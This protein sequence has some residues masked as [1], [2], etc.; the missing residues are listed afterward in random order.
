MSH[1]QNLCST[2]GQPELE[3]QHFFEIPA[4]FYRSKY[5]TTLWVKCSCS[6]CADNEQVGLTYA[7]MSV[8]FV[9]LKFLAS[10]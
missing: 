3:A 4:S 5:F 1:G 10:E 6:A 8:L 9:C 2:S 7:F